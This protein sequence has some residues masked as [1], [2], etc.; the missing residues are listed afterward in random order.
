MADLI[1]FLPP[2]GL[3]SDDTTFED[4]GKWADGSN[5]RF[6]QG[7]PECIGGWS[8][9]FSGLG[10]SITDM[11][12][13]VNDGTDYVA[14]GGGAKLFVGAGIDSETG[15][16]TDV[17][18]AGFSPDGDVF[19]WSLAA[20]GSTLLAVPRLGGLYAMPVPGT[21]AAIV[22][23]APVKITCMLVT[24]ER[25]VLAFGCNEEV[26]GTFNPACIRGSD[27]EDYNVWTTLPTNNCFEHVLDDGGTIL[28][29]ALVGAYVGVWTTSGLWMGQFVGDPSQ[30]YRFDRVDTGVGAVA[31][32]AVAV[33]KGIA[34]WVGIDLNFY[35]W[36]PGA[37]SEMLACPISKDFKANVDVP[38]PG[39]TSS[40][41]VEVN[42]SFNEIW[43]LYPDKRDATGVNCSRYLAYCV[44]ESAAA[45]AAGGMAVWYR[46]QLARGSML[47]PGPLSQVLGAQTLMGDTAGNIYIHEIAT[48]AP[49]SW[50]LQSADQ[51]L[52]NGKTRMMI[53]G[54]VPDFEYQ[55]G[56]VALTL[57][58][59]DRPRATA[60]AKGPYTIGETD[61]KLDFRASG[62]I[63]AVRLDGTSMT[64]RLGKPL[65]DL[66]PLGGR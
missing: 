26:S 45:A 11:I 7:K 35:R 18:P 37:A 17:T 1:T 61:T 13:Y 9:L 25:Q 27:L 50:F 38:T 5:V 49:D 54:F 51:Y 44:D 55:T 59:R 28:A 4:E 16:P 6:R 2:P 52:D 24:Q 15:V 42:S 48:A 53:R 23:A 47:P 66:V 58:M 57:T 3:S 12:G 22:A 21:A 60:V 31:T 64:M 63:A 62:Q 29:A 56:D 65:F 20:F 39:V 43:I 34:Y 40:I 30:A 46:G 36:E 19:N 10:A 32:G 8:L 41:R 33:D 14:Y